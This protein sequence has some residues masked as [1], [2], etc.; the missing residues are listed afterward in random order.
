MY[1][2]QSPQKPQ[3]LGVVVAAMSRNHADNDAY[4][5]AAIKMGINFQ[6]DHLDAAMPDATYPKSFRTGLQAITMYNVQGI[7]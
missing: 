3:A 5:E 2:V 7:P 6:C 4:T 1:W